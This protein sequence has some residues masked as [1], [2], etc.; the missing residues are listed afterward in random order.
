MR[1]AIRPTRQP[2]PETGSISIIAAALALS[3][4]VLLTGAGLPTAAQDASPSPAAVP[5]AEA[6]A[7]P[8]GFTRR[9]AEAIS[10][11]VD[12]VHPVRQLPPA[13]GMAYRAIDA[14]TF[15][16]EL[17]AIFREEYSDAYIAAEDALLTR[18]GLIAEDDDLGDLILS[19]YESQVLAFYDPR[20]ATFSLVGPV[21]SIG[22]FE[23]L[24]VAHEYGHALQDASWDLEGTRITDLSRA[25]EIL[26]Q[27]ALAEGDATAVMYDW[28]ARNLDLP[29][30]LRISARAFGQQ[31]ER[32]LRRVPPLLRRQ[33]EFPYIDGFA[34]VNALR[35]RG[36]WEAVNE[37]WDVRPVS[38][39]Q[40]LHPELYPG[41]DPVAVALPDL[42]ALLGSGWSSSY[43][44]TLGEMQIGVWVADGRRARRLF[45]ALPA[46]LPRQE[47]AAGW[48]G[49]R[50]VSLD[51]PDGSWAV[52]WQT[53]WDSSS[54]AREFRSAARAAM[55][56]LP[57]AHAAVDA[58][59]AG[60]LSFPVLVLVADS[61]ETLD[62][63]QA[64]LDLDS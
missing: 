30:L 21:D 62:A 13:D 16:Q 31:D 36:D 3:I 51:G 19:L 2:G 48:G 20:T 64:V 4:L 25:D 57:G 34:F 24:V 22:G 9:M 23:S 38:T 12:K 47:A 14:E 15:R 27:Q 5:A 53:D 41:E 8:E 29:Q 18:L 7:L 11:V 59:I 61:S 52:V 60:G 37:A 33:L 39:E 17:E 58:D 46:Q 10:G 1:P 63:V 32:T 56:D 55:R 35:G 42:A 44:Q 40:I 43:E 45:P 26:A 54:D 28:A 50:L 6:T 49:D